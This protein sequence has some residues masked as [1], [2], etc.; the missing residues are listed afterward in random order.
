MTQFIQSR[1]Q[2][3][4]WYLACT[5]W[6]E[7]IPKHL[8][9]E[10]C[11]VVWY[12]KACGCCKWL[13]NVRR[14][15]PRRGAG[16]RL[17]MRHDDA[18]D[19]ARAGAPA[20]LARVH[21]LAGLVQELRAESARK[22]VAQVVARARLRARV[23]LGFMG[24]HRPGPACQTRAQSCR[25]GCGSCPPARQGFLGFTAHS[26]PAVLRRSTGAVP[27]KSATTPLGAGAALSTQIAA[28]PPGSAPHPKILNKQ[29]HSVG[30]GCTSAG[31]VLACNT[32]LLPYS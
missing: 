14:L 10:A 11:A 21:Q 13:A 23:Y 3:A 29:S 4:Q 5:A 27:L 20:A 31:A 6:I 19:E 26:H 12:C 18:A 15:L 1:P 22:V 24:S 8:L 17:T 25:P 2:H 16:V 28:V 9:S 32:S 7:Q 30:N